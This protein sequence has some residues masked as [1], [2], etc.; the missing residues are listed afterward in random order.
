[1]YEK[2]LKKRIKYSQQPITKAETRAHVLFRDYKGN[3]AARKWHK[4]WSTLDIPNFKI[5]K[6]VKGYDVVINE[7]VKSN[8]DIVR[9]FKRDL[10]EKM[11]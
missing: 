9:I 2:L 7:S 8:K 11:D 10:S 5:V 6:K 1:L 3:D 4:Q